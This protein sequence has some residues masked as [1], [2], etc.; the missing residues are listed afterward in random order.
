MEKLKLL[1]PTA[2]LFLSPWSTRLVHMNLIAAWPSLDDGSATVVTLI[3]GVL[4]A[5]ITIIMAVEL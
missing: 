4:T 1:L 2:F 5:A 3:A